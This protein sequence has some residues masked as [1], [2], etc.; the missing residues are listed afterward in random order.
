MLAVIDCEA[1][2]Y[3]YE[4]AAMTAR[5]QVRRAIFACGSAAVLL[6]I[7]LIVAGYNR[8]VDT[9]DYL[10]QAD[11]GVPWVRWGL[12]S[13]IVGCA[14]CFFGKRWWRIA[15]VILG[16]LLTAFWLLQAESLY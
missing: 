8:H 11:E 3:E 9:T 10:K 14:L 1:R 2:I 16:F 13:S 7:A 6:S 5:E 4:G 12:G 15:G